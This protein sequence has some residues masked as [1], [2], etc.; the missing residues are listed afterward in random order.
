[1]TDPMLSTGD[2]TPYDTGEEWQDAAKSRGFRAN[3]YYDRLL[4]K[5]EKD[6]TSLDRLDTTTRMNVAVYSD[7]KEATARN[8]KGAAR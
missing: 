1:M 8:A 3:D 7:F 6:P 4:A 2:T 5:A